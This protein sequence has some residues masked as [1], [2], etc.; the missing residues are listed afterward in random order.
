VEKNLSEW[1]ISGSEQGQIIERDFCLFLNSILKA[2][3]IKNINQ[4]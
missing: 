3:V 4:K 1:I 2:H